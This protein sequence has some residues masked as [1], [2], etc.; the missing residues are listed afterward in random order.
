MNIDKHIFCME[1]LNRGQV[2]TQSQSKFDCLVKK[3]EH[4][5]TINTEHCNNEFCINFRI[6]VW[7][8]YEK[9]IQS[10]VNMN[11]KLLYSHFRHEGKHNGKI[12]LEKHSHKKQKYKLQ[13]EITNENLKDANFHL[14]NLKK[15]L[16]T[17]ISKISRVPTLASSNF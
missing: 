3:E 15:Y 10:I 11:S 13:H 1:V 9:N 4:E 16:N 17:Q 8:R 12:K 14:C 6:K 2:T 5:H 7:W